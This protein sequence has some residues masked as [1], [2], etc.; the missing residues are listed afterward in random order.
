MRISNDPE[1]LQAV[2]A[3][4]GEAPEVVGKRE[5]RSRLLPAHWLDQRAN[6]YESTGAYK[7]TVVATTRSTKSRAGLNVYVERRPG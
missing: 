4:A 5:K 3:R 6:F 1:Y 7:D 2:M